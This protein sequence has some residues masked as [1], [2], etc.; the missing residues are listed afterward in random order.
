MLV[1]G[2]SAGDSCAD[3]SATEAAWKNPGSCMNECGQKEITKSYPVEIM[4][5]VRHGDSAQKRNR[6][7]DVALMDEWENNLFEV[8]IPEVFK[9]IGVKDLNSV[10]DSF[11]T[12][13]MEL[14][15]KARGFIRDLCDGDY[16][17]VVYVEEDGKQFPSRMVILNLQFILKEG[18]K[19]GDLV[20]DGILDTEVL[21][22]FAAW[23]RKAFIAD[24]VNGK[25][26]YC[27]IA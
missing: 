11:L 12:P 14:L 8:F 18:F 24:V 10:S 1:A 21:D 16:L 6:L 4:R 5:G 15:P 7:A 3:G 25:P 23:V 19:E 26:E 22:G 9:S 20:K 17:D 13:V 2:N 27:L